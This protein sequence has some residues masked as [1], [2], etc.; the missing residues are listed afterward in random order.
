MKSNVDQ[1]FKMASNL[2]SRN[3]PTTFEI[4]DIGRF[5]NLQIHKD[6]V[7]IRM[8][9]VNTMQSINNLSPQHVVLCS[10]DV[11]VS[12]QLGPVFGF[13][14]CCVIVFIDIF[15]CVRQTMLLVK[16]HLTMF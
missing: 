16:V 11:S 14:Q 2:R 1:M 7:K 8:F 13:P 3:I 10:I 15:C 9:S 5:T 12:V 4:M 6:L